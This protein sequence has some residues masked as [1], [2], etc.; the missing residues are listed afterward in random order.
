[1]D[2][3]TFHELNGVQ[4]FRRMKAAGKVTSKKYVFKVSENFTVNK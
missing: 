3:W 2:K 4:K 1:M